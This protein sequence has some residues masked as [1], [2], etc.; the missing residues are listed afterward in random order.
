MKTLLVVLAAT[1][2]IGQAT[3][4]RIKAQEVPQAVKQGLLQHFGVK[5]ADWDKEGENYEA[6]FEQK[7]RE[8]SIVFDGNGRVLETEREIDKKELPSPVLESLNR[9]YKDFKIEE[10]ARIE[11]NGLFTYE[12][13]VEREEQTLE[14]LFDAQ[15]KLLK[16]E[17]LEEDEG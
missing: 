17:V 15:G 7:G 5:D 8:I 1:L 11:S 2:G 12:A 4:Q 14:L 10:I 3:A 16:K 6:G 13:E 9:D